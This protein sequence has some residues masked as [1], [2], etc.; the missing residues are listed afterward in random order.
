MFGLD[1]FI[2]NATKYL[3]RLGKKGGPEKTLEDIDKAIQYLQKKREAL[4]QKDPRSA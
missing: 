3:F 2:G 1:Y 4:T